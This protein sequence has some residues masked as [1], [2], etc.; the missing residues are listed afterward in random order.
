M[1]FARWMLAIAGVVTIG[2]AFAVIYTDNK[3]PRIRSANRD[4][5]NPLA[6]Q[7]VDTLPAHTSDAQRQEIQ[8]LLYIFYSRAG[9]GKVALEDRMTIERKLREYVEAGDIERAELAR[10][11]AEVSHYSYR[12]E[13]PPDSA[14]VHPLLNESEDQ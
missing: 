1:T 13:N 7:F 3:P 8:N 4:A 11:M 2:V 12:L 5:P 9:E 14:S 10:F 6:K